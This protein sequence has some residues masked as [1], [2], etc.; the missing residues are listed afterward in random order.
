[1]L[2]PPCPP[3]PPGSCGAFHRVY[4][5]PIVAGKEPT[6]TAEEKEISSKRAD[7]VHVY[8]ELGNIY[9]YVCICTL[10]YMYNTCMHVCV[11][12]YNVM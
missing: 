1:M 12:M 8:P 3:C 10:N 5:Q 7:E 4:E 6:A 9:M 11:Y 2:Y